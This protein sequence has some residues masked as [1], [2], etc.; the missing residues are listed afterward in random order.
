MDAAYG[1][2]LSDRVVMITGATGGIGREVARA[3]AAAGAAVSLAVHRDAA[4]AEGLARALRE[5]GA[6]AAVYPCDVR[7]AEQVASWLRSTERD[8]GPPAGLVHCAAAFYP[9]PGV[10]PGSLEHWHHVLETNLTGTYLVGRA[11]AERMAAGGGGAIVT[12][13]S[14]AAFKGHGHAAYAASKGGVAALTRWLAT[15]YGPAGVRANCLVPG[16]IDAGMTR[17]WGSAEEVDAWLRD[18]AGRHIVLRRPGTAAEVAAA[19]LWLLSDGASFVT[20]Q[21]IAVNGG[22]VYHG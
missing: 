10:D 2:R 13:A 16:V 17:A 18:Y 12:F 15:R 4:A 19:A 5:Q 14:E 1:P 11:V 6:A 7:E 9:E 22:E 21:V 20:G 8:L 3:C